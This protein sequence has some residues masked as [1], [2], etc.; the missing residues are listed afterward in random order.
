MSVHRLADEVTERWVR[1]P[2]PE[3]RLPSDDEDRNPRH[4]CATALGGLA[5]AW[6]PS[7]EVAECRIVK[8]RDDP[9]GRSQVAA[10]R[11]VDGDIVT[12]RA[13]QIRKTRQPEGLAAE[14]LMRICAC[15]R[16]GC[17]RSVVLKG[18]SL[19]TS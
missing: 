12:V 19:T 4:D 14:P 17:A 8:T 1:E 10:A 18:L 7:V 11:A 15:V 9:N 16:I 5:V 2:C 3:K 6:S 13:L